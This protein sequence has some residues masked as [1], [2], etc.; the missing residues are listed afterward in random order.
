MVRINFIKEND[1]R[2]LGTKIAGVAYDILGGVNASVWGKVE[3]AK[4]AGKI[5]K[6]GFMEL[7]S[8]SKQ[9]VLLNITLVIIRFI[10]R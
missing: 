8:S 3:R 9:A 7:T 6:T 10:A 1:I 2:V 4:K 5:S